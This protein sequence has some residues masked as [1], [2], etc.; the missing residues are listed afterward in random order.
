MV[1]IRGLF[2]FSILILFISCGQV[3]KE[4][5]FTFIQNQEGV[6]LLEGEQKVFFYQKAQVPV[7]ENP[8]ISKDALFNHYIHPLYSLS[9]DTITEAQPKDD[10]W[11]L[12]HRGIFWAWHQIFMG[13]SSLGD[14]WIMKNIRYDITN[15]KTVVHSDMAILDLKVNWV[16]FKNNQDLVFIKE[17]SIIKVYHSDLN[18]RIIDFEITLNSVIPTISIAGSK[19]EKGYGG[20]ST[21]IKLPDNTIFRSE[22]GEVSPQMNQTSAGAWID[23]SHKDSLSGENKGLIIMA[24][25]NILNTQLQWILRRKNSMQNAVFPGVERYSIKQEKPL[26]LKYRLVIHERE[27]LSVDTINQWYKEYISSVM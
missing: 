4:T 5:N 9:G 14:G 24:S 8:A 1:N 2:I 15:I 27:K 3:K 18:K 22:T 13:D 7:W 11:H 23:I 21:R 19:G 17:H 26:I 25:N 16:S 10:I 6:E 20:F 12:H